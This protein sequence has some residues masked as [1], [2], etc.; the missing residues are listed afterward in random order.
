VSIAMGPKF[1]ISLCA[2]HAKLL[3]V[4]MASESS[5]K[6]SYYVAKE[7]EQEHGAMGRNIPWKYFT[8]VC[9]ARNRLASETAAK[10]Q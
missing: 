10:G 9:R 7:Q 6:S 5:A 3:D 2:E 4:R 1:V 8:I